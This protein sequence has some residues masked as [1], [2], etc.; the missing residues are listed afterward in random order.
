MLPLRRALSLSKS[1]TVVIA[2]SC[3]SAS[4]ARAV[5]AGSSPSAAPS[6]GALVESDWRRQD[7]G[8]LAQ[9]VQPGLVR[10][11]QRNLQWS[12]VTSLTGSLVPRAEAPKIDGTLSDACWVQAFGVAGG[13]PWAPSY[14]VCHDFRNVYLAIDLPTSSEARFRGEPTALDAAGAVDGVEDGRYGFH[15]GGDPNPWWQ[16]DLGDVTAISRIVVYNRLDYA[17]GL[18]NQDNLRILVS[19]DG[20]GWRTVYQ[21]PGTFF[22][23]VDATGPLEAR[24]DGLTA[25]F[26]RLQVPSDQPILY[27]LDE[28]EVYGPDDPALN[29]ALNKPASQSTLSIWSRGGPTGAPLIE[30][31]GVKVDVQSGSPPVVLLNGA[32]M[33]NAAALH[34]GDRTVIELA[35]PIDSGGPWPGRA[36]LASADPV[37]LPLGAGWELKWP[38]APCLGYGRNRLEMTLSSPVPLDQPVDVA[39][40]VTVF[41]QREPLTCVSSPVRVARAGTFAVEFRVPGEGPAAVKLVATQGDVSISDGRAFFVPPVAETLRRGELLLRGSGRSKPDEFL[42]L[43]REAAK[44]AAKEKAGGPDPVARDAQYLRARWTARE[45]ALTGPDMGFDQ[46]LFVKR[47]TQQPYPDVCLNHMPWV[48][49]PGGDICVLSPVRPDGQVGPVLAGAVGPG[50]VHG[51]DLDW[52][53]CKVVFGYA[54]TPTDQPVEGWLNRSLSYELRKTVEPIHLFEIGIDGTGLRQLTD[55][56]WSD[57]DPAYLPNGDVAFVSER[58]G[59]SLQCNEND[60]DETSCN[61]YVLGR[62]GGITRMSV[63]KD[64]DYLPHVLANGLLGYTRWEYEQR[65]WANIQSLWVI[66][67]DGTG[68]DALFK[69][70][71]NNPWAIEEARS[72]PGTQKMVAIATGHHTLPV[73]V[74]VTIDPGG[75][76]NE[77]NGIGIV[78]PG[79]LSPEGGMEGLVVPEGGAPG[80]GGLYATPYALSERSFLA[81]YTYGGMADETGY[82][83]YFIDVYGT[84]ELIYRDQSI[85]CFT[86]I[87]LRPRQTPTIVAGARRT[88]TDHAT[89]VVTDVYDGL[90]G[91]DRGAIKYLRISQG[92]PWPY[93]I[94]EGGLRYEPDVKSVMINWNPTRVLG[95]VPV[96]PDGSAYFRVPAD[97]PVYFQALDADMMEVRR[98]RSFVSFQPGEERSCS[99]CHETRAVAPVNTA[100]VP[101]AVQRDPSPVEPAPWG[102]RPV[103]FLRDI[104]PLLD[105]KCVSCHS[106]LKPAGGLDLSGGLTVSANRAWE[107]IN[108]ARLVSRSNVGDDARITEPYEFGSHKSKLVDMLRTKR[109]DTGSL[110]SDEWVRIITWIDCNAPYHSDF[111]NKRPAVPPYD[112]ASDS[113]LQA[114]ILEVHQRRCA[115]CHVPQ[116]VSGASW[117]DIH[118][119]AKTPFLAAPLGRGPRPCSPPPYASEDDPDYAELLGLVEEAVRNTW[120]RPRRDV[121]TLA[122]SLS[123]PS[124]RGPE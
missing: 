55:G 86:P 31:P 38:E 17:P 5:S 120:D 18:H 64:G 28:V 75:G 60:K 63:T 106:G 40:E 83:L 91:V 115:S 2:V 21:N 95:T 85:S 68:A 118:D 49:R 26:V 53:A 122:F 36:R 79:V 30:L 76:I 90:T 50:H 35:L 24:F 87:P 32:A 81:S 97:E 123:P 98:M 102:D 43:E 56:E 100:D 62:D 105:A 34:E 66:R 23:G 112:I 121:A 78:T 54:K 42:A 114:R 72:V 19:D 7:E 99:G 27:H 45:I 37:P 58:C 20:A 67:P 9:I 61:L 65:N 80:L 111:I 113:V 94:E 48:S 70:H 8:R 39:A 117:I 44:L 101:L 46:L 47:L 22:G 92:V 119:A 29:L 10:F 71:F 1:M 51:M 41:T 25:R 116:A 74:L 124:G 103:S 88:D 82:A 16:V 33:P 89:C 59:Y 84:R 12:G 52:D 4:L 15:T 104:Q 96:E 73:G 14:R 57:L 107:A 109:N 110:T 13:A 77:P 11:P 6:V 108:A 3:I 69:Q 93:T